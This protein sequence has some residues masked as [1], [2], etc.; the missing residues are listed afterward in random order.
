MANASHKELDFVPNAVHNHLQCKSLAP[1]GPAA[2]NVI[3][4]HR[5]KQKEFALSKKTYKKIEKTN[6]KKL[7]KRGSEK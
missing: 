5:Q 6:I 7:I 2:P 1:E 3:K 4:A